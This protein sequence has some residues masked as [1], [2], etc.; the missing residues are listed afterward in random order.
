[1]RILA[2]AP[3]LPYD[4]IR[5]AGGLYLLRHLH[6]LA[7]D[8]NDVSLIV[9]GT[10]EQLA[11]LHAAPA[12]LDV[13]A[14]PHVLQGR[15]RARVVSDAIYRRTMNVP[16]S[17][18]AESLRSVTAAGL[19]RRARDADL[20]ELHWAE[21]A[22]FAS[23][24]R[25]A[26]VSTAIAVV[27]HDVDLYAAHARVRRFSTGYRRLL[28][29]LTA[30][31][32]RRLEVRG[33]ARADVVLVFKRAD[34]AL[35]R[36][37][38]VRTRVHVIEP[39]LE[40]PEDDRQREPATVLFTGALWRREN[41][42]GAVWF[43]QEVWPLVI[44]DAPEAT[45]WLVGAEP[46]AYLRELADATPGVEVIADVPDLLP[47]YLTASLFVAPLFVPGGLKFKVPQAMVCGLPVVAT[48]V[49]AEGVLDLA[50][51]NT[52]LTVTNDPVEM[53]ASI[54]AAVNDPQRASLVGQA[55]QQWSQQYYSFPHSIRRLLEVYTSL[56]G[57]RRRPP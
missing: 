21:Y 36:Q 20:V 34:E 6:Q 24:L 27:E 45:F 51:P 31:L 53:A 54:T 8:G 55:A 35:I 57:S 22:R 16:P 38:G 56:A 19:V 49:A 9:P 14:G 33:L 43:L 42:D 11:H 17:P 46:T 10:P 23:V 1:M 25:R 18:S 2:V 32:V 44:R 12:W 26:G 37:A 3:Y 48:T 28:G 52:L 5:H 15:T 40:H 39:W 50:P 30:P 7:L 4:D 47:F 29:T 41:E 13:V